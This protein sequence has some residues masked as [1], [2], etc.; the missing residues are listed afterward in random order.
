MSATMRSTFNLHRIAG[1]CGVRLLQPKAHSGKTNKPGECFC[2]ATAKWIG[3]TYGPDH[4]R[5]V[6]RLMTGTKRNATCLYS[7]VMKAVARI[8]DE[9]QRIARSPSLVSDFD[10]L[11]IVD[12]RAE[13]QAMK[14]GVSLAERVGVLLSLRLPRP[15][16]VV[17]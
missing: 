16:A 13:A 7:D 11:D 10:A 2:K 3:T 12:L 14:C 4:L 1:E 6:F 15:I 9:D 5:L 8:L 17:A